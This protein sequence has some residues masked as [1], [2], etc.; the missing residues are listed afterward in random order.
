M[1]EKRFGDKKFPSRGMYIRSTSGITLKCENMQN[2]VDI[3]KLR[4]I[5]GL[6]KKTYRRKD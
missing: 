4:D 6:S 3:P 5:V 1:I 2:I